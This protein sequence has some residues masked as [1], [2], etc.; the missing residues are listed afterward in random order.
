[1]NIPIEYSMHVWMPTFGAPGLM[2]CTFCR[3][4]QYSDRTTLTP[5]PAR[6]VSNDMLKLWKMSPASFPRD[7]AVRFLPALGHELIERRAAN[8]S[9]GLTGGDGR[10]W[11]QLDKPKPPRVQLPPW[12]GHDPGPLSPRCLYWVTQIGRGWLPNRRI[13]SMGYS[14]ATDW[15][16]VTTWEYLNVLTPLIAEK[17]KEPRR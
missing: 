5:C 1:M 16:G 6:T 14:G 4:R 7:G 13:S 8:P 9:R 2:T 17:R 15:F 11:V 12:E 3:T 10:K